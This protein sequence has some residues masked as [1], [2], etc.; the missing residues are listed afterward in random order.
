M[1]VSFRVCGEIQQWCSVFTMKQQCFA[2][3]LPTKELNMLGVCVCVF[4]HYRYHLLYSLRVR[5]EKTIKILEISVMWK[6]Q[7]W[8]RISAPMCEKHFFQNKSS[9]FSSSPPSFHPPLSLPFSTPLEII[10][11]ATHFQ[12]FDFNNTPP[13]CLRNV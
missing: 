2:E 11:T 6:Q 12:R 5:D 13:R 1:L 4:T 7:H 9:L 8:S 10:Q 3:R